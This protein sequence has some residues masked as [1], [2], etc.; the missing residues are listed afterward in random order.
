MLPAHFYWGFP[1]SCLDSVKI[2]ATAVGVMAVSLCAPAMAASDN[3]VTLYAGQHQQM[4]RLLTSAFEK[5]SGIQVQVR[6]GEGPELATQI[7]REGK[8]T[9]ADVFFTEN[10]PALVH[11]QEKGSLAKVDQQTLQAVPTRFSSSEGRWVGVL[12][13]ENVLT[14]NPKMVNEDELP[15]SIIGLANPKWKDKIGVHLTSPDFMPVIKAIELKD[16]KDKALAWL[17]GIKHNATLYQHSS[18]LVNAVNNGDVAVGIS[19]SYYYYRLREQVGQKDMISRVYH[20]GNGDPGG[21]IS[22]SGA[23]VLKH[24]PHPEAAQKLLAFM[25]SEKAQTMLGESTVD[26][27]YPLRRGVAA[28]PQLKP[29]DQLEPPKISIDQLGDNSDALE[30]L[31]QAGLM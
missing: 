26:F 3:T 25:V 31:Q 5:E 19:N 2:Y 8:Q 29:M 18:G 24:A 1:M 10:T 7:V 12:A 16:G 17:K 14:Y 15:D 6:N 27:E 21:Q 11:L 20:F 30:L 28:N 22:V 9:P 13:R 23:A 4:V